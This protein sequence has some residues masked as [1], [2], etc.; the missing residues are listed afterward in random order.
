MSGFTTVGAHGHDAQ[1][2][3]GAERRTAIEQGG[4]NDSRILCAAGVELRGRFSVRYSHPPRSISWE[5]RREWGF[6]LWVHEF[7]IKTLS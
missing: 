3:R 4:E 6:R 5:R 7:G 1:R 2:Q